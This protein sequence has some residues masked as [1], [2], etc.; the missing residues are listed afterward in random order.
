[1]ALTDKLHPSYM[2]DLI[3]EDGWGKPI[4]FEVT[5]PASFRFV[6]VGADGRRGTSDDLVLEKDRAFGP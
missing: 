4:L 3:R 6:S 1:V 5:G 2:T